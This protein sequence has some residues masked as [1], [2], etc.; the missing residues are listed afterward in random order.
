LTDAGAPNPQGGDSAALPRDSAAIARDPAIVVRDLVK[1]YGTRNVVDGVSLEVRPG[2]I[3]ALLGPN[4]AGKTTTVEIIEGYRRADRGDARVLGSDPRRG[5]REL[6]AR[7]GLMLQQGGMEPRAR[8]IELVRL[9]AAFHEQPRNADELIDLVGLRDVAKTRYR[10]LSGGEK[11]RLALAVALVG[12]PEVLILDEPTAGMD[13]AARAATRELIRDLRRD[14]V[15]ILMTTHDLVD[16]ERIA[17]RTAILVDGRIVA[18]GT[19]SELAG[20]GGRVRVRF[21]R[22]LAA[23][24]IAALRATLANDSPDVRVVSTT[25]DASALAVDGVTATP[26]LI[27]A[28]SRWAA[29]RDLLITELRAATLSLE[30]RYLEL[31]GNRSAAAVAETADV[32]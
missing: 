7:V 15:A 18:S 28:I 14:G 11:Q 17:D 20:H 16:V 8:A 19:P 23:A 13:P 26:P 6:R 29:D 3:F 2:E 30:D 31:T 5:G 21:A 1:R 27:A 22:A 4:G 12:R 9:F 24:D 10:S 32:A 25:G